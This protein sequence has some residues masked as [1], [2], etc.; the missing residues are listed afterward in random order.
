[1]TDKNVSSSE[2]EG[3]DFEV[4]GTLYAGLEDLE[5]VSTCNK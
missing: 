3:I 1:M 2:E 5:K 4:S